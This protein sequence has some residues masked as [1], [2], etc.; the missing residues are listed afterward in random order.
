MND[1]LFLPDTSAILTFLE[2]EDGAEIVEKILREKKVILPAVVL[3]E[4]FYIS[5]RRKGRETGE[6]RYGMLK[7]LQ[8][9][10]L[11]HLSEPVIMKAGDYKAAYRLSFADAIIA[12]YAFIYEATLVHKDPEYEALQEI[13]QIQLP[14]KKI[15]NS[16]IHTNG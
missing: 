4:V 5:M 10:H 11:D 7:S 6:K 15:P 16:P 1:P 13:R 9:Q 2:N 8:V 3:L 14:Y 12:A